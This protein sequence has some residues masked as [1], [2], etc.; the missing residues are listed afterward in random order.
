MTRPAVR[1][2]KLGGSLLEWPDWV[3]QFRRW[4]AEQTPAAAVLLVGGGAF[5]DRLRALDRTHALRPETTHWLA[6]RAMSLT[7]SVAAELLGAGPPVRS[8]DAVAPYLSAAP[9]AL[10]VFDVEAF[11]RAEQ[12]TAAALP[13][14][15]H[16]TSDSI[17][18]HLAAALDAD[19]LVLLKSALPPTGSSAAAAER[20]YVDAHF[21]VAA[22]G[23]TVRLVNLRDPRFAQA[24]WAA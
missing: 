15:W 20:G 2:V 23:L 21:P 6:V 8:L 24:T 13:C 1:V 5:V 14:G 10:A 3:G 16:V 7:A 19:E 11:L 22:S 9:P 4:R 18:A 17:A 12:G